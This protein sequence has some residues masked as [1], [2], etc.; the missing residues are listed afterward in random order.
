MIQFL[1]LWCVYCSILLFLAKFLIIAKLVKILKSLGITLHLLL[2]L[3]LVFFI[4]IVFAVRTTWFQTF[5]AQ[6]AAS[7]LSSEWGKEVRIDKLELIF[8]D[9]VNIEGVYIQDSQTDTLLYAQQLKATVDNWNLGTPTTINIKEVLLNNAT[10][11]LKKYKGDTVFNFQYIIDYFG[12]SEDTTASNPIALTNKS[13]K[14]RNVNFTYQD[15]NEIP[16]PNGIDYSNLHIQKLGGNINQFSMNG[17]SIQANIVGL[18]FKDQSGIVLKNLTANVLYAPEIIALNKINIQLGQTTLKANYFNLETPNGSDDF[19]DFTNK[20]IFNSEIRNSIVSLNDI[21]YF[22]PQ[23]WGMTDIVKITNCDIKGPVNGMRLNNTELSMLDH[24]LLKGNFKIPN[25]DDLDNAFIDERIIM[26]RTSITDIEKL[27]LSPFLENVKYYNVPSNLDKANIITL[28]DGHFTGALNDFVVDGKITSGLG[29]VSSE[30]GLRFTKNNKD[31]LYY[32]QGTVAEGITKDVIVENL[33]LG[34]ITSNSM[35][36]KTTGYLKIKKGSKG[37]AAKDINLLFL[38]KFETT[39]LNGY[40]YHNINIYEGRYHNDRFTG[41]ID[42]EDDNLAL[43]YDGYI[44]FKNELIFNF[45]ISI[46]SSF[47]VKLNLMEGDPSTRLM[48]QMSVN[49]KGTSLD[50]I[51]GEVSINRF[52]YFNGIKEL[53]FDSLALSINRTD[54]SNAIYLNSTFLNAEMTGD[55]SFKYLYPL[56]KNQVALLLNNY[57]DQEPIPSDVAEHFDLNIDIKNI[58]PLLDFFDTKTYIEPNTTVWGEFNST[59]KKLNLNLNSEKIIYDEKIFNGISFSNHIDSTKGS[60]YYFINNAQI[61]DSLTIKHLYFDSYIKPNQLFTNLGWENNDN[62]A[63]SLFAFNTNF[64]KEHHI[65]TE[66]FPSFFHLAGDKWD[67]NS[68][69]TLLWTPDK[70]VITDF[71]IVNDLSLI[72]FDGTLSKNP[73]DWLNF[74]IKDFELSGLNKLLSG[75]ELDGILNIEGGVS[76]VYQNVRFMALTD[77]ANLNINKEIVGDVLIDSKWDIASNSVKLNGYLKRNN[78][79]TFNFFGNYYVERKENS[80]DVYIAFD[81]TDI[82]FLSA[83]SDAEL[84]TDIKGILTGNLHVGG[85]LSNPI[86]EGEL[87]VENAKVKVPMFNVSYGL[88][89]TLSFGEGEIIADQLNLYDQENHKAIAMMQIYHY[90]WSNWN[91]DITLDMADPNIT[92]TFLVMDTPYKDGEYYYGKAYVTGN[93][94]IFGYDNHTDITVNAKTKKGTEITLPLYGTSELEQD[95]FIEFYNPYDTVVQLNTQSTINKLGMTLKMNFE[96]TKAAKM[97]IIFDPIYNDQIEAYGEGDIEINM[98]DYGELTM[99]GKYTIR[100]G[101]YHMNMKNV[102]AEDF[103]IV[104]GSTIIWTQSPYDANI[105]IKTRFSRMVDMSDIMTSSLSSTH[106]RD[107]VYGYL[108]L[109]NSLINPILSFDIQAPNASDEAQKALNQI[110]G[111]EEDLNKQ[112]FALLM[113][114]KFIPVAGSGDGSGGANV[115]TDLINQQIDAVLGKIGENYN[116]KSEIASNKVAFGFSTSFLDDKLK[117]TTSVGVVSG[118]D[119]TSS[120]ASN[121]VGDVNI[122]YQLNDDGSFTINVF[123]ESNQDASSQD[124]GNFTQGIGLHYQESFNSVKDFKLWQG[125]LNIFRKKE[126]DVILNTKRRSDNNRKVKVQENFDPNKIE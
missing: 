83:F 19:S 125:F 18:H 20:V 81:K 66:F 11:K 5:L 69:S 103:E 56:L 79:E 22:V 49:I 32:Y 116:L 85:I 8:F 98:D 82:A 63:P 64:E 1:K 4:F 87:Q 124:Q 76:D 57:L 23:I 38:G 3:I 40:T 114:K 112:F 70:I 14:L 80:L 2:E 86:I 90:N 15:Q 39:T 53:K 122:E 26:F 111:V 43:N 25:L 95:N 105:D 10:F 55:F 117:V 35:L 110:K 100:E 73:E 113:L 88:D 62:G 93:V 65:L 12:T 92:K 72:S 89:G 75:I 67:I 34:A 30:N 104:D 119:E 48:T 21:A 61:T 96:V 31:Q 91:Y 28:R 51:T 118:T 36:G 115:A 37:F 44:D 58:N 17:D 59:T 102:V 46:D 24:T 33:D 97:M 27:N 101:V 107:L 123:N 94:N 54:S 106:K 60:I 52:N 120:S 109:T 84:Y 41:K 45:N 78:K 108:N 47:L 13:L 68:Q 50:K 16:T 77:V 74:R 6:K 99:F 9:A 71:D 121:I 29:N 42:V 7:Y 126:K